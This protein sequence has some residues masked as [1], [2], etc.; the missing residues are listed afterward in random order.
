MRHPTAA[1]LTGVAFAFAALSA[2][3]AD[4][5][6]T[7]LKTI[8]PNTGTSNYEDIFKPFF[9]ERLPQ[10]SGGMVTGDT[11]SQSEAGIKG[12]EFFRMAR[13]GVADIIAGPATYASGELP[14]TD[15]IEIAGL[16]QDVPTLRKVIDAALPAMQKMYRERAQV[17]PVTMWPTG[18]QGFWCAVPINGL[19]DMAGKKVRVFGR[20]MA[21]MVEAMG[22]TPVTIS[23]AEVVPG[24][25]RKVIDCAVTGMNS[26]N[27]A[28]WTDVST[29]VY[30]FIVGWS[31]MQMAAN[32]KSWD[33]LDPK[34]RDLIYSEANGW[35]AAKGWADA[36]AATQHGI[37]C[38]TGDDRCDP[39][40]TKPRAL[41][42][43]NLT[44]VK[45]TPEDDKRRVELMETQVLPKFAQ[46]C[47]ADCTE[48]F[49]ATLAPVVGIEAKP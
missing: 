35:A 41:S 14:L 25:Q 6:R 40:V 9:R 20:S 13:L 26:G 34:V 24:L 12:P 38:S 11:I 16:I 39:N 33:R 5:P 3:A 45:L 17:V 4:F 32:E 8:G 10:L 1:V 15:S 49:N 31:V 23:F 42:R 30:P 2:N 46:R 28:K 37:W 22:A 7:E 19:S 48:W 27:L 43:T 18:G 21:D 47:G 29:H 36:E 44:L